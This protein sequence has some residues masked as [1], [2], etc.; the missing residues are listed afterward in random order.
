MI[1][2]QDVR[3]LSEGWYLF[4]IEK[5]EEVSTVYGPGVKFC[6]HVSGGVSAGSRVVLQTDRV[7]TPGN[8]LGRL[9]RVSGF[10]PAFGLP[11]SPAE[12]AGRRF[13]GYWKRYLRDG[14]TRGKIAAFCFESELSVLGGEDKGLS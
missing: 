8:K 3:V 10:Y 5:A 13:G 7:A 11:I 9:C 12:F 14:R 2:F 6:L 1:E 4:E